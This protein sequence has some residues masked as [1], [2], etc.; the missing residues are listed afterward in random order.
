MTGETFLKLILVDVDLVLDYGEE[1][2]F[3][4]EA[5]HILQLF[6]DLEVALL[7]EL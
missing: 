7:E 3:I 5:P 2:V 6:L 4:D 1:P